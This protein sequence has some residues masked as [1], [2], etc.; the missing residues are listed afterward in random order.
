M[1]VCD[2]L[3]VSAQDPSEDVSYLPQFSYTALDG[4]GTVVPL[5]TASQ[6]QVVNKVL[7]VNASASAPIWVNDTVEVSKR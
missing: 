7:P 5:S 2:K 1:D 6:F 4:S 3:I